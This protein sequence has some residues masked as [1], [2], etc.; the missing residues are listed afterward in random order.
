MRGRVKVAVASALVAGAAVAGTVAFADGG[1]GIRE[2]LTGYEEDPLVLSTTGSGEFSASIKAKGDSIRYRLS[3]AEL[4]GSITQA[5]IHFGG[6]AQSGGISVWLCGNPSP[7]VT[8]PLGTQAVPGRA[9]DHHGHDHVRG[10]W[11]AQSPRASTPVSST[12][13][14][15]PSA[16]E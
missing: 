13:W 4:E 11:S 10:T 15:T 6:R 1:N 5:H 8:P 9:G 16:P 3:Y 14:S 7:T 2:T 12:S